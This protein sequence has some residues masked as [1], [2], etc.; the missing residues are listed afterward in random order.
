ML[1]QE[2]ARIKIESCLKELIIKVDDCL[3]GQ[4]CGVVHFG[5]TAGK[6]VKQQTDVDVFFIFNKL[7]QN[8]KSRMEFF[9]SFEAI[10]NKDLH[11]LRNE[12]FELCLSP[13]LRTRQEWFQYHPLLLDLAY[14]SKVLVDREN[15]VEK[16]LLAIELW[17]ARHGSVRVECGQ[18]WYWVL[19]PGLQPHEVIDFNF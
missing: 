7:P 18:K 1:D 2:I 6:Y 14:C 9:D 8:R 12:G 3:P 19:Q 11:T 16:T 5:S 17:K 15:C 10:A 4:L 13:I